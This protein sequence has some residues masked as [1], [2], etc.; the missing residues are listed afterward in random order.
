MRTP[1]LFPNSFSTNLSLY[2]LSQ[3][4][5]DQRLP[6]VDPNHVDQT[7]LYKNGL[8]DLEIITTEKCLNT[9]GNGAMDMERTVREIEN[10]VIG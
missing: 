4:K 3:K 2:F 8:P 5:S 6:E 7:P 1:A 9:L 10:K